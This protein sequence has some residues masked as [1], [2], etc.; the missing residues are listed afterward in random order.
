[1]L[2]SEM[3]PSLARQVAKGVESVYHIR[4]FGD[5]DS[6]PRIASR[7]GNSLR[8]ITVGGDAGIKGKRNLHPLM[9]LSKLIVA[10]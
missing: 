10:V 2:V 9:V 7:Q 5:H 1:M 6:E 8:Y 3:H 4:F